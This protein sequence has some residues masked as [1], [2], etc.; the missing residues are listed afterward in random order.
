MKGMSCAPD[1]FSDYVVCLNDPYQSFAG[2]VSSFAQK[3]EPLFLL[4]NAGSGASDHENISAA[5]ADPLSRRWTPALDAEALLAG[6][7]ISAGELPVSPLGIVSPVVITRACLQL[8]QMK[9]QVIDCGSF[10][11][12]GISHIHVS[13]RAAAC[14]S[15]GAALPEKHVEELFERGRQLADEL[16]SGKTHLVLSECVP[17]GTTTALALLTALGYEVKGLL[18]SSLPACNH[19]ERWQLVQS[20]LLKSK[21]SSAE[22][23][24]QPLLAV[25]AVGDPMQACVAGMALRA[26]EKMPVFLGGG[27]QMLAVW[28]L[29]KALSGGSSTNFQ[30]ANIMVMTTRWVAYDPHAGVVALAQLLGAPL[31]ASCPDF[32]RSS[33]PGLRAYEEGHVKEGAGAGASMCLARI[34]GFDSLT[35]M[36]AIDKCYDELTDA[37][38]R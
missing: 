22:M 26:A 38:H 27:S 4:C 9:A 33:K 23:Q 14:P 7:T 5:G 32:Y 29:I 17:G 19:A 25:S 35:I 18:S 36:K 6:R 21:Y 13:D 24:A 2:L 12:P 11:A 37:N 34:A 16:G 30:P 31:A 10:Y 20:G 28:A 3:R 15:S 1:L 8:L